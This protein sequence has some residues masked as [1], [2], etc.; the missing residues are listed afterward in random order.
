MTPA[1]VWLDYHAQALES[2]LRAHRCGLGFPGEAARE[3][4][5]HARM[6]RR[7]RKAT[8]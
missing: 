5:H 4:L 7:Y 8:R 2:A 6:M 3:V 1:E